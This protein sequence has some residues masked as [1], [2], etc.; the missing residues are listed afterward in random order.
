M[1]AVAVNTV[2][3]SLTHTL[4]LHFS[5]GKV[6]KNSSLRFQQNVISR[7]NDFD[8][9][10]RCQLAAKTVV[11]VCAEDMET[12]PFP[13]FYFSMWGFAVNSLIDAQSRGL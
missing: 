6:I 1:S 13:G 10:L 11:V 8:I 12:K 9:I 4:N 7:I 3:K 5:N 2:L